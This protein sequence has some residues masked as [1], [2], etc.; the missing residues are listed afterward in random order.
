[1][2]HFLSTLAPFFCV[3]VYGQPP[4]YHDFSPVLSRDDDA[5]WP[6]VLKRIEESD[7]ACKGGDG[8]PKAASAACPGWRRRQLLRDEEEAGYPGV[9]AYYGDL[10]QKYGI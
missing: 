5:G 9:R 4:V 7:Q 2:P 8:P 3:P 10:M 1:M 6:I